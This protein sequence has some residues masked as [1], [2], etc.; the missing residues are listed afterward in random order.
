M[1]ARPDSV[2]AQ[3][4]SGAALLLGASQQPRRDAALLLGHVLGQDRAWVLAHPEEA[5]TGGQIEGYLAHVRRRALH[6]PIQYIL[7]EQEF[8]GLALRVTPAVLIPRPETEHLV[9]AVLAHV[10]ADAPVRIIDVGTGSGAI[11]IALAHHRPSAVF[12]ALDLSPQ[13]LHIAVDNA[14]RHG[15]AERIRF[16]Q[17]DLLAAVAGEQPA[18]VIV[19]NPPYVPAGEQLE[20]QVADWE[21]HTALFAGPDGMDIYARL[22]PQALEALKP[23]GLLALELGAGQQPALTALFAADRAWSVPVFLDD[24]RGIAR[25]ATARRLAC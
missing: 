13:A 9:E 6:E 17:S 18:D 20:P 2:S 10:A 7:G 21:P 5:L 22:L 8:Y 12:D 24:L 11:A 14:G 25:V 15:V 4:S 1:A 23:G 3:L 19:A 16:R